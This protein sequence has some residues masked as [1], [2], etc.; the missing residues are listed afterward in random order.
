MSI[1]DVVLFSLAF[2]G[3][4]AALYYRNEYKRAVRA[5]IFWRKRARVTPIISAA[6][7]GGVA[8]WLLRRKK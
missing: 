7:G 5:A 2:S 1:I 3:V 8:W 6:I 4:I